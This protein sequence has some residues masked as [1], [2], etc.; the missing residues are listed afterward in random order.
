MESEIARLERTIETL[1]ASEV[2]YSRTSCVSQNVHYSISDCQSEIFQRDT[3]IANAE[4]ALEIAQE[5]LGDLELRAR[6]SALP[7]DCAHASSD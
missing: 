3:E 1:E 7:A 6:S 5:K 4:Q 2:A